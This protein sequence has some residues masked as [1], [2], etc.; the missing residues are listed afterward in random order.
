MTDLQLCD[1]C[2]QL[3]DDGKG[4]RVFCGPETNGRTFAIAETPEALV[5]V[6]RGSETKGDWVADFKFQYIDTPIGGVEKGF[7]EGPA[8][9]IEV[10]IPLL[11]SGKRIITTGH[12][13]GAA[14]AVI[15]ASLLAKRGY[16]GGKYVVFACP[17]TGGPQLDDILGGAN[18][19][20]RVYLNHFD[21]VCRVP[22]PIVFPLHWPFTHV[23]LIVNIDEWSK[24]PFDS[25]GALAWHHLYLYRQGVTK[26]EATKAA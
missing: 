3:Y 6:C 18:W 26:A 20:G 14:E 21:I 4:M 17:N 10:L 22:A 23:R 24:E 25:Y 19:E 2:Q 8:A 16:R 15:L 13:L 12:S 9:F 7:Y 11:A 5:I 1:L